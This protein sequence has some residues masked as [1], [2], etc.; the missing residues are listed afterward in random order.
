MIRLGFGLSLG[1]VLF[2]SACATPAPN[3][4]AVLLWKGSQL[5]SEVYYTG[6]DRT[7]AS[8][9]GVFGSQ[10]A[11]GPDT[12]HDV[13]SVSK[14]VVGLE[15]GIVFG[16]HPEIS[17][18]TP[19][20]RFFPEWAALVPGREGITLRHLLTMSTGLE[21]NEWGRGFLDSDETS[22]L[23]EEFPARKVLQ[24]PPKEAP[25]TRFNYSGGTTQTLMQVLERIEG[26]DFLLLV[27]QDLFGP[28]GIVRWEWTANT[29]GDPL[30]F[31]GLR[32][33]PRDMVKLGRLVLQRGQWEGRPIVPADWM[34][35]VLRPQIETGI[36]LFSL[37]GQPVAYSH[38]W[39]TGT[40][41]GPAGTVR[42]TAAIGNGGQRIVVVPELDLVWVATAG[43][44]GEPE[45]QRRLNQLFAE[46]IRPMPS[47]VPEP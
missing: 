19:V 27:A 5:V 33:T 18:D 45:I 21:W 29:Q 30:A 40:L 26:R 46:G 36:G 10:V 24:K 28:L 7:L 11:F 31:S 12:L 6:A 15:A 16:R 25:G 17:L 20:L 8:W 22:L 43:N 34:D 38:Q 1:T 3:L 32:L 47:P 44:Y 35:Q 2:L 4:H 9:A 13:R 41:A 23:W 39:W 14:S 37:D 42:W